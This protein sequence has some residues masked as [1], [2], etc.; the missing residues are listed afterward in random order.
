[1]NA[2]P[3]GVV[4][5]DTLRVLEVWGL[6]RGLVKSDSAPTASQRRDVSSERRWHRHWFHTSAQYREYDKGLILIKLA[7]NELHVQCKELEF[8]LFLTRL[9][10]L[11]KANVLAPKNL[12]N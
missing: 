12:G 5:K 9:Q 4:I 10:L 2:R 8:I 3:V 7:Q 11:K 6:I 1:M